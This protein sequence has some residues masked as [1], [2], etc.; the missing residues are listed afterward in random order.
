MAE[1]LYYTL[2]VRKEKIPDFRESVEHAKL[3][4]RFEDCWMKKKEKKEFSISRFLEKLYIS[5][6][7]KM[8]KRFLKEDEGDK[9]SD[10]KED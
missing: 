9:T 6:K 5:Y 3:D 8:D 2:S 10:S 1:R 4:P 7:N